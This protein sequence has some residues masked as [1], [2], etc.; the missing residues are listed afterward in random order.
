MKFTLAPLGD[1]GITVRLGEGISVELSDSVVEHANAV[2]SASIRGVTDVVPSYS[3]LGVFYNP[4]EVSFADLS[5]R[6]E[7]VLDDAGSPEREA[8]DGRLVRIPITYDGE[9]MDDV[10]RQAK[11]TRSEVIEIHSGREY[12]VFV[13]GFVPGFAYLG[14]LDP[15]LIVPRR[16][17]PR[18][19]VPAGSVAIAEAQ[20]G[21]YP[22]ETPGGWNLIGTT[23]ERMFD[24]LRLDPA[25]LHVG[26]K[27]R[28]EVVA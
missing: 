17:S 1:R 24:P 13:V 4:L 8:V 2:T 22:S 10:C 15:R 26:D 9:D 25:L 27:V 23:M 28:F 20:T 6:L 5:A 3:S 14:P 7:S 21:V 19:K 12:R 18:K 11:L 16:E